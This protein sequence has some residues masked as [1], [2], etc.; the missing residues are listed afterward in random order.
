[1]NG[2]TT[3][4][5]YSKIGALISDRAEGVSDDV[6]VRV[7]RVNQ[8][9]ER[10]ERKLLRR[11]PP[12]NITVEIHR[13]V[14]EENGKYLERRFLGIQRQQGAWRL[15]LAIDWSEYNE[16]VAHPEIPPSLS[17]KPISECDIECWV[18]ASQH[19]AKLQAEVDLT[20]TTFI[21][22][23]DSTISRLEAALAVE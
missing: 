1:M 18:L 19:W 14:K 12:R 9:W 20:R 5:R 8:L 10:I 4:Y 15:C 7:A 11:Q 2:T 17:W 13:E 23:L 3:T 16:Q 21:P 6:D 22:Q